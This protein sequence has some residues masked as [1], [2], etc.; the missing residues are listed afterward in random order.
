M[1]T[2]VSALAE[3]DERESRTKDKHQV[4]R[5]TSKILERI[6]DDQ[7]LLDLVVTVDET[8][9]FTYDPETKRQSMQWKGPGFPRPKKA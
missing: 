9:I 1:N 7:N 8:W 4:S 5:E 2:C 3:Y 6:D